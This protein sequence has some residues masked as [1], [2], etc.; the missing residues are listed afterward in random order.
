[1]QRMEP[2]DSYFLYD[3]S[4]NQ[5]N[6]V[7][8][9][10]LFA[11][12]GVSSDELVSWLTVRA[13][14]LQPLHQKVVHSYGDIGDP[15]W[16]DPVPDFDARQHI[17]VHHVATWTELRHSLLAL[18][19]EPL[20]P[21]RPL[22]EIHLFRG[23]TGLPGIAEPGLAVATKYHHSMGDAGYFTPTWR[24]LYGAALTPD[25]VPVSAPRARG[26]RAA[27]LAVTLRELPLLAVRPF[28]FLADVIAATRAQHRLNQART[29]PLPA[30]VPSCS[31][32]QPPGPEVD[33]AVLFYPKQ[34]LRAAARTLGDV[35]VNDLLLAAIGRTILNQIPEVGTQVTAQIAISLHTNHTRARNAIAAGIVTLANQHPATEH[36]PH[37]HQEL[38]AQ[39]DLARTHTGAFAL[40]RAPGFAYTWF[41]RRTARRIATTAP[42]ITSAHTRI[43]SPPPLDPTDLRLCGMP[44]LARFAVPAPGGGFGL[45]H[46]VTTVGDTIAV[47][48]NTDPAQVTSNLDSYT[49]ELEQQLHTLTT[50]LLDRAESNHSATATTDRDQPTP[51]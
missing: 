8:I 29:R 31:I 22:W 5:A 41:A 12:S 16:S 20:Q 25:E 44:P 11:D 10:D 14:Q 26:H 50:T 3:T 48:I 19:A 9:V 4:A 51:R 23:V 21:D 7:L 35:S 38:R 28:L 13:E 43:S 49:A 24:A 36:L 37:L 2:S 18:R 33:F 30:P 40:P 45:C 39:R 47:S 1:M 27:R 32:T 42:N 46:T 17:Y 15:Y 6:T 34:R